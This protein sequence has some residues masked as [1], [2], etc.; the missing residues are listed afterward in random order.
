MIICEPD[1]IYHMTC[2]ND[3]QLIIN[4]DMFVLHH[5]EFNTGGNV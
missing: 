4:C 5:T 3:N 2:G 1:N